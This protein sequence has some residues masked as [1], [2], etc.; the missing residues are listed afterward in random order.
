MRLLMSWLLAASL[1]PAVCAATAPPSEP[2]LAAPVVL[3][4]A[5]CQTCHDGKKG[6][7]E[8]PGAEGKPRALHS[9]APDAFAKGVHAKMQCVACHTDIT[10]NAA[11]A[12]AHQKN[13]VQP[14]KRVDC[15][16][17][18]QDLW[19]KV[20]RDGK[21]A[22]K[23]RLGVVA[24]NI[25]LYKKSFH[26][27]PNADD[28]TIPN[29]SC[30]N[31][32][33]THSFNVPAANSPERAAWRLGISASCGENCHT[34]QL[35][36]Y[37]ESIHGKETIE[38]HNPK[39]AVC[40]D[41]HSAHAVANSSGDPFKLAIS[42][43]CG[44]CHEAELKSYTNT[45]GSNADRNIEAIQRFGIVE[46]SVSPYQTSKWSSSNDA[47]CNGSKEQPVVCYTNGDPTEAQRAA[48]RFKLPAGR[49]V[50]N[51]RQSIKAFMSQNKQAVTAGMSFFYQSWNH[52]GGSLPVRIANTSSSSAA[53][54][55]TATTLTG[56]SATSRCFTLQSRHS[57]SAVRSA[58]LPHLLQT[59]IS[60]TAFT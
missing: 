44:T 50:S 39:S 2:V 58:V 33:D 6:K 28:K 41:C 18:H 25:D 29:A 47:R 57:P 31:C 38:K 19:D 32:H 16:G 15:A 3:D 10:D 9:I 54:L 37:T 53:A 49:W 27:R 23:P 12:N 20:Q 13:T 45:E 46:E 52:R 42:A 11:T 51:K 1:V 48:K 43:Q 55:T 4:N 60:S 30:D 56:R 40:T 17:C 26:A 34:D 22:E 21:S 35:E 8:V 5:T 7:L 24:Q 14:L 59:P 36:A